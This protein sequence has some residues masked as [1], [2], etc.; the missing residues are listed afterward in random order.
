[1]GGG[2]A[3]PEHIEAMVFSVA[4]DWM[5]KPVKR[6][7][8]QAAAILAQQ[9]ETKYPVL[10]VEMRTGYRGGPE[11]FESLGQV[12]VLAF[13]GK[14]MGRLIKDLRVRKRGWSVSCPVW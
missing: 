7:E 12:D 14:K 2:Q 9:G 11:R 6:I 5:F 8:D 10:G 4:S 1:M 3:S 13:D